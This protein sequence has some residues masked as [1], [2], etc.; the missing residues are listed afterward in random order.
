MTPQNSVHWPE[1]EKFYNWQK[2]SEEATTDE[3]YYLGTAKEQLPRMELALK[4]ALRRAEKLLDDPERIEIFNARVTEFYEQ[5]EPDAKIDDFLIT[6][7][8]IEK[9]K[10]RQ[11]TVV[12]EDRENSG[13]GLR[14]WHI[15]PVNESKTQLTDKFPRIYAGVF[16]TKHSSIK[17]LITIFLHEIGHNATNLDA[18]YTLV[19]ENM[20]WTEEKNQRFNH[21]KEYVADL[22]A[23]FCA[24]NWNMKDRFLQ[25]L[26]ENINLKARI[27]TQIISGRQWCIEQNKITDII[28][29]KAPELNLDYFYPKEPNE[30]PKYNINNL[31]ENPDNVID[32][33]THPSTAKRGD[34]SDKN[35]SLLRRAG[36]TDPM[37]LW[38]EAKE[39]L[40]QY[41][42]NQRKQA[43]TVQPDM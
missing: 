37:L 6:P 30:I 22:F 23:D 26:Q 9:F 10:Q 39:I 2:P 20:D 28:H 43:P 12:P 42:N 3:E 7:Q 5:L 15:E 21:M 14:Q 41:K 38:G 19:N 25:N 24:P 32:S 34:E 17:S 33:L 31:A 13:F 8:K 1:L 4:V 29:S 18:Y 27:E 35:V 11:F 16:D 40:L 36:I